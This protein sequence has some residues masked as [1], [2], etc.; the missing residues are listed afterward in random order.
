VADPVVTRFLLSGGAL[1]VGF[2]G[3]LLHR[4]TGVPEILILIVFG[5]ILGP[6]F[7]LFDKASF[8][9]ATPFFAPLAL[10]IILFD[11]GLNL[12][13]RSVA[14]GFGVSMFHTLLTFFSAIFVFFIVLNQ[15]FGHDL[16]QSLAF[17]A[18]LGGT[19]GVI[20]LG[21]IQRLGASENARIVLAMESVITDVLCVVVALTLLS[22]SQGSSSSDPLSALGTIGLEFGIALALGFG[23]G[24]AWMGALHLLH[25]VRYAFV[26]TLAVLLML[27][28]VTELVGGSGAVAALVFGLVIG[29]K[30]EFRELFHIR[31]EVRFD[32][33]LKTFHAEVS[34]IVRTFFFVYLGVVFSPAAFFD[35][36]IFG[37]ALLLFIGILLLR[38]PISGASAAIGRMDPGDWKV[39]TLML[40][41]GLAAAA[42]A[43]IFA[44]QLQP[45][46][47]QLASM[48]LDITLLLILMTS[49]T[50]TLSAFAGGRRAGA[51]EDEADLLAREFSRDQESYLDAESAY[52]A[53]ERAKL[54]KAEGLEGK[55]RV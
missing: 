34:F 25:G 40:P 49:V 28:A 51:G 30:E 48:A 31:S 16:I 21:L 4:S 37:T 27:Y 54:A 9:A 2:L 1:A 10:I 52:L 42:L 17:G 7:G 39:L 36:A 47:P 18:A 8:E 29:N 12:S 22:A 32:E 50:A 15:V 35:P 5:V 33:S 24:L 53:R 6:V 43:S 41:R 13:A 23:A 20:V 3:S 19:S 45:T 38:V 44:V 14:R 26:V 11:G 46:S 55:P